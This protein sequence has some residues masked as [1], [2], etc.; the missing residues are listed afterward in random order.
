MPREATIHLT[1]LESWLLDDMIRH[2][3]NDESRASRKRAAT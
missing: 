1:H 2:T 3:W